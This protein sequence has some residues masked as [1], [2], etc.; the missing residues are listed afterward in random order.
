M[1]DSQQHEAACSGASVSG[2]VAMQA[3]AAASARAQIENLEAVLADDRSNLQLVQDA[4]DR[5]RR[6]ARR[7]AQRAK[8]A[9]QRSDAAAAAAPRPER[10]QHALALLVGRTPA[11]CTAP[12]FTLEEF[13]LPAQLAAGAAVRA[14]A[15]AARHPGRRG[16]AARRDRGRRRRERQPI[17]ADQ[18]DRHRQPAG[19]HAAR[20]VRRQQL[21]PAA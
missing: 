5:G 9:R 13:D 2:N 16:A 1:T 12:D 18:P 19:Q 8:P 20:A 17:S 6:D 4:F 10:G 15:S 21:P 3:L 11:E 14:G 7:C